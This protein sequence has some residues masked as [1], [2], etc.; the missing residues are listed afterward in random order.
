MGGCNFGAILPTNVPKCHRK[1]ICLTKFPDSF[2]F[3][4]LE[5]GPYLSNTGIP[6]AMNTLVQERH[7]HSENYVT[8]K[9]SG[10][11]QRK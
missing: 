4:S 2:E 8:G 7:N 9:M 11:T 5:P 10:R 6:E 3:Y 1:K